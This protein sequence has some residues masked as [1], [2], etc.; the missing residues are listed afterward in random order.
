GQPGFEPQINS[1]Y[2]HHLNMEGNETRTLSFTG[3]NAYLGLYI[4][5]RIVVGNIEDGVR[6]EI[7]VDNGWIDMIVY[8]SAAEFEG[9]DDGITLDNAAVV[10]TGSGFIY[11]SGIA[12]RGVNGRNGVSILAGSTVTT[13]TG[14][15]T[16]NG[17]AADD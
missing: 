13:N 8:Q 14:Q 12:G 2:I 6:S 15:I 11:L 1:V 7:Q 3:V 5:E 17:N 9:G 16:I 4:D 10:A